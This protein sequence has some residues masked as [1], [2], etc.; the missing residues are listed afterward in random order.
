M[1]T[2]EEL[3]TVVL[4]L[5]YSMYSSFTSLLPL[6]TILQSRIKSPLEANLRVIHHFANLEF[7]TLAKTPL[8]NPLLPCLPRTEHRRRLVRCFAHTK[9]QRPASYAFI[10]QPYSGEGERPP[11]CIP[12]TPSSGCVLISFYCYSSPADFPAKEPKKPFRK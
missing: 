7:D 10:I 4:K 2:S 9:H 12:E 1:L 6:L 8:L 11:S 3:Q 5:T